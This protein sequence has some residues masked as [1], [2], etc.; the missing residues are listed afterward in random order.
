MYFSK[1]ENSC[2]S[3]GQLIAT[4]NYYTELYAIND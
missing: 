1:Y 4:T 3:N 2:E